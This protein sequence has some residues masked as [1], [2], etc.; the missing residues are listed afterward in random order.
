MKATA[1]PH[2]RGAGMLQ[3]CCSYREALPRGRTLGRC[4]ARSP[5]ARG[6]G[7]RAVVPGA[8]LCRGLL[9]WDFC[10]ARHL[11]SPG[12]GFSPRLITQGGI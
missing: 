5:I 10:A 6:L 1:K 8:L 7:S 9:S 4:P 12:N 11:K 3:G 2:L